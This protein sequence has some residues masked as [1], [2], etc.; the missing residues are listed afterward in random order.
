M[1][2]TRVGA[3]LTGSHG[4]RAGRAGFGAALGGACE[5]FRDRSVERNGNPHVE[6]P[7]YEGESERLLGL[8]RNLDAQTAEDALARL[9]HDVAVLSMSLETSAFPS[10]A[11]RVGAVL[12]RVAA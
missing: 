5:P 3:T 8:G 7:P 1:R 10:I 6:T 12:G 9:I 2:L 4:Q 11:V